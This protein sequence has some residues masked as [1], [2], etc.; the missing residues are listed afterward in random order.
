MQFALLSFFLNLLFFVLKLKQEKREVLALKTTQTKLKDENVKEVFYR[1][2]QLLRNENQE[3]VENLKRKNE[4]SL[5]LLLNRNKA[6]LAMLMAKQEKE[7][8]ERLVTR[9]RK[10]DQPAA[11]ECPVC[12]LRF[13]LS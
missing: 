1:S 10:A 9:K 11:P 5:A 13:F 2:E 7:K 12:D 8:E 6:E 4:E 3:V